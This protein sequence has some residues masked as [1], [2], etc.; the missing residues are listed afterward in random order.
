MSRVLLSC[1]VVAIVSFSSVFSSGAFAADTSA[2]WKV[3]PNKEVC[4]VTNAHFSRP[5]IPVEAGGQ[6]YYGCCD[7]CKSTLQND[8]SSRMAKDPVSNKFVD[9]SKAVIA[10]SSNGEVRYFENKTNFEKFLKMH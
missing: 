1:L 3:V 5:Q 4:M 10:A 8:A 9:K 2:G 6:T 7:N